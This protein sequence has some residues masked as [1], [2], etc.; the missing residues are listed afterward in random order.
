MRAEPVP[1]I[2]ELVNQGLRVLV[3][4]ERDDAIYNAV[5]FLRLISALPATWS[6]GPWPKHMWL[7]PMDLGLRPLMYFVNSIILVGTEPPYSL[8]RGP[9]SSSASVGFRLA[10]LSSMDKLRINC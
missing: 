1:F 10:A 2:T 6:S 9:A 5:F 4:L 8:P 7:V 3:T